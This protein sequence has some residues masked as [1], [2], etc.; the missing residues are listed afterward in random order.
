[1]GH[2]LNTQTLTKTEEQK[3]KV[4]SKFTILCWATFI[5]IPGHRQPS[6]P[7]LDTPEGGACKIQNKGKGQY[8]VIVA[9]STPG[10]AESGYGHA[11]MGGGQCER[12]LRETNQC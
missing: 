7:W 9:F 4:L 6:G 10:D 8:P 3:K 1:M 12:G 2:T 11:V 5:A